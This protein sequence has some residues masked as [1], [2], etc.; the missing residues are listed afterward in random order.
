MKRSSTRVLHWT[1]VAAL[2]CLA[3]TA[4]EDDKQSVILTRAGLPG[5]P[6]G[7]CQGSAEIPNLVLHNIKIN[8][9]GDVRA[10]PV[11]QEAH[12]PAIARQ[13]YEHAK[14]I[15]IRDLTLLQLKDGFLYGLN[16]AGDTLLLFPQ[17]K[18]PEKNAPTS[19]ADIYNVVVEGQLSGKSKEKRSVNLGAVQKIFNLNQ[20]DP[21]EAALFQ[22]AAQENNAAT[23][24]GYLN[25]AH[26]YKLAEAMSGLH[27]TLTTCVNQSLEAYAGGNYAALKDARTAAMEAKGVA[28]SPASQELLAKVEA[29]EKSISDLIT[30]ANSLTA[31]GKWDESLTAVGP[32][33]KYL[34]QFKDLDSVYATAND[35]SYDLHFRQAGEKLKSSDFAG[36]LLEYETALARK[37]D[38]GEALNGRKEALIRKGV[39]DSA[40]LRQQKQPVKA[41]EQLL[42]L[43]GTDSSIAQ[44]PRFAGELKLASCDMAGQLLLESQKLVLLQTK[45]LKPLTAPATEKAFIAAAEKLAS[46]ENVCSGKAAGLLSQVRGQLAEFHMEHARK[47][48]ARGA[49]ATALLYS[50]TALRY[51]PDNQEAR[52][53]AEQATKAAGEK[54]Q[55]RVGVIFR[56]ASGQ[57]S[58]DA[59]QLAQMMQAHLSTY[60]SLMDEQEAHAFYAAPQQ[61]RRPNH[62][63]IVG[64]I[65]SCSV[66][67]TDQQQPVA[68]HYAVPNPAFQDLKNAEQNADQQYKS[69]RQVYGE[70]NCSQMR[71]NLDSIKTQRKNTQEWLKYDYSY[72]AQTTSLYGKTSVGVQIIG[73]ASPKTVGPV[74]E[75][76]RDGCS[77]IVGMRDDDETKIGIMGAINNGLQQYAS[78]NQKHCPL[79]PDEQYQAQMIQNIE[80]N[81]KM[82]VPSQLLLVPNEYLKRARQ[83]TDAQEAIENYSLFLLSNANRDPRAVQDAVNFIG[84]H[85]PDLHPESLS[86]NTTITAK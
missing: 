76:V 78:R 41:R 64:Q 63:L 30:Q 27:E 48:R 62:L 19:I 36:A 8:G 24:K 46:A 35:K 67:R 5:T 4:R 29:E 6:A 66:Q 40:K 16:Q 3:A 82:S 25:V 54:A 14:G 65:N 18:K 57:C 53:L 23:W 12:A 72:S 52:S 47:A 7:L 80:Q 26:D 69:C 70:A 45:R 32:L 21:V 49:F 10:M 22:H 44:D 9:K 20:N 68:S 13:E 17:D 79:P 71:S 2:L 37:P 34:G 33:K 83:M 85:D 42:A 81:L 55:V 15:S 58:Q 74:I 39:V 59:A 86:T 38:S 1:M 73:G 28:D 31:A 11:P 84:Q 77:E 61:Q 43:A 51:A 50:Q 60:Y 75:D 56:D